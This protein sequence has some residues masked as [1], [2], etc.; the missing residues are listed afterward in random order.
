MNGLVLCFS[1][2][3]AS[4]FLRTGDILGTPRGGLHQ[5]RGLVPL[6][7]NERN[8]TTAFR[9]LNKGL[10]LARIHGE[11][12]PL[13]GVVKSTPNSPSSGAFGGRESGGEKSKV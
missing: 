5:R 7:G 11:R 1:F 3:I 12:Q 10:T 4:V 9:R 13:E 6:R 8:M 2:S